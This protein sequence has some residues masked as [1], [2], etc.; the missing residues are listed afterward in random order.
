MLPSYI[1]PEVEDWPEDMKDDPEDM[2]DSEGDSDDPDDPEDME[3]MEDTKVPEEIRA[4]KEAE[5][6]AQRYHWI[7]GKTRKTKRKALN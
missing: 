2:E 1:Q 5:K 4:A 7:F 3:D 6:S